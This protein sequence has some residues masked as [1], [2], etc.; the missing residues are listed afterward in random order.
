LG[1][2]NAVPLR[3]AVS[4]DRAGIEALLRRHETSSMFP[5]V[6][7]RDAT[8]RGQGARMQVW[9]APGIAGMVGLTDRGM[10]VPQWPQ[11]DWTALRALE[12]CRVSGIVG[13]ADQVGAL[14]TAMGWGDALLRHASDEPGFRLTLADL[15]VPDCDGWTLHDVDEDVETVTRWRAAYQT[16]VFAMDAATAAR[17]A[18][19]E[20]ARWIAIRSH[21]LLRHRGVAVAL[22][23]FNAVLPEVVQVGGVYVPPDRRGQGQAR[24]VVGLH[25]AEAR[26]AGVD[27][28]VLFA[29][30]EAAARAYAALGFL[31]EG[32]MGLALFHSPQEVTE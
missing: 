19:A 29:A 8:M 26:A 13:P 27:R 16:E 6:N 12:G 31:P 17:T 30:S 5:L 24:R 20:V 2:S 14:R 23:G 1:V 15:V 25:L 28:A 4:A 9:V 7:L 3:R 22:S 18:A 32:R 10:L 11:G 21:R